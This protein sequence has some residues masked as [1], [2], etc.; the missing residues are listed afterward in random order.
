MPWLETD[1][2]EQRIAF[3][4]E[5]LHPAANRSALCRTRGISRKTGYKWLGRYAAAGSLTGLAERSRRPTHSP[6]RTAG[7]RHRPRGGLAADLRLGRPQAAAAAC[8]RRHRA[9]AGDH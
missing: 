4:V 8:G 7:A 3:V 1:V 6:A 2:Q 5:A 9:V